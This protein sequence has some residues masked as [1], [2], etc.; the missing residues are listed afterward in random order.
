[1]AS[2]T[3]ALT[4]ATQD[5]AKQ[6]ARNAE[7]E[8]EKEAARQAEREAEKEAARQAGRDQQKGVAEGIEARKKLQQEQLQ[9]EE[10]KAK[11]KAQGH[12][13]GV[14]MLRQILARIMKGQVGMRVEMWRSGVQH[15]AREVQKERHEQRER[16]EASEEAARQEIREKEVAR[17]EIREKEAARTEAMAAEAELDVEACAMGPQPAPGASLEPC[18]GTKGPPEAATPMWASPVQPCKPTLGPSIPPLKLCGARRHKPWK[19]I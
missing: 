1:M 16:E 11:L 9:A 18:G 14:Q 3:W 2:Y 13:A 12:R 5:A 17:Q 6:G 8:A 10:L 15:S 7:R 19:P 4:H